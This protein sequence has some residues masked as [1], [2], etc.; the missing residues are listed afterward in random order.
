MDTNNHIKGYVPHGSHSLGDREYLGCG[1]FHSP[2]P[3]SLP[4]LFTRRCLKIF[5]FLSF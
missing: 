1:L 4:S 5:Q 3:C 2:P